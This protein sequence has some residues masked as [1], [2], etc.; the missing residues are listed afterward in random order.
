M[1]MANTY[2]LDNGL[3]SI[4]GNANI[5]LCWCQ[6]EPLTLADCT[7][8]SGSGGKRISTELAINSEVTLSDGATANSR[9]ITVPS[10]VFTDGAVIGVTAGS[11]DLWLAVY[12]NVRLLLRYD[13][14]NN[15]TVVQGATLISPSFDFGHVQV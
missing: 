3:V 12:D 10:K 7:G 14:L 15:N 8:L 1:T 2:V 5:K 9:K 11:A 13:G 6:T 4:S